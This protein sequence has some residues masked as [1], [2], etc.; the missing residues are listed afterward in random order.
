MWILGWC[1]IGI[2]LL[3]VAIVVS[4]IA[5]FRIVSK[6]LSQRPFTGARPWMMTDM[7]HILFLCSGRCGIV[8]A[9]VLI[10]LL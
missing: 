2:V 10:Y 4:W 1:A 7:K 8:A 6:F 9:F 3:G 5:R